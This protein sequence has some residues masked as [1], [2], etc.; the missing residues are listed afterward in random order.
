MSATL[1]RNPPAAEEPRTAAGERAGQTGALHLEED[2]LQEHQRDGGDRQPPA[3]PS[4]GRGPDPGGGRGDRPVP[5]WQLLLLWGV[6]MILAC[7]AGA[8]IGK[9]GHIF[10]RGLE[11]RAEA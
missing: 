1:T 6:L 11:A 2:A 8:A 10:Q 9:L 3:P 4:N 7:L 5:R